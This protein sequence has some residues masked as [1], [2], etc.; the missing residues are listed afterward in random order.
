M[1]RLA[2]RV[3][4]PVLLA[5]AVLSGSP[6]ARAAIHRGP[7][8]RDSTW[9]HSP[10]VITPAD[11][12]RIETTPDAVRVPDVLR[13]RFVGSIVGMN[14]TTLTVIPDG[15]PSAVLPRDL[16]HRLELGID[17]GSRS[18]HALIGALASGCIG[19][20]LGLAAYN[21]DELST[22]SQDAAIGAAFFGA[23]GLAVG[24]VLPAGEHWRRLPL[25]RIE[26]SEEQV[27]R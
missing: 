24:A 1:F 9:T 14:E 19:A 13:G 27:S 8:S 15:G 5:V 22:R 2:G 11:R 20:V 26:W 18:K 16:V 25:E 10:V 21:G 3:M 17:H 7:A 12:V 6:P 23:I 4:L